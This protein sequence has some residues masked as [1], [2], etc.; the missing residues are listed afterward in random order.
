M[1]R[2]ESEIIRKD[3]FTAQ[4]NILNKV[5]LIGEKSDIL[6][7]SNNLEIQI[8]I[9]IYVWDWNIFLLFHVFNAL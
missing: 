8:K 9:I 4:T 2:F 6:T 3:D 5:Y 7:F 1:I